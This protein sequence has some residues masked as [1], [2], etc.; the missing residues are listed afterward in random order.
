MQEDIRSLQQNKSMHLWFEQI[1]D[2]LNDAGIEKKLTVGT[3]DV[4]WSRETVK[5]I[6]KKIAFAQLRKFKTSQMTREEFGKVQETMNRFLAEQ[7]LYIP[8]P[9]IEALEQELHDKKIS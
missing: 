3:V 2:A 6:F 7:G 4:P 9:S 5:M 1:A 8:F